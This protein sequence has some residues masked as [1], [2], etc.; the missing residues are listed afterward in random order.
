MGQSETAVADMVDI[1]VAILIAGAG[2]ELQGIKRGLIEMADLLAINKADG[3]NRPSV[4]RAVDQYRNAIRLMHPPDGPWIPRVL[5]CTPWR[6]P[7]STRSGRRCSAH[8]EAISRAG[9][10][11]E[12]RQGQMARWTRDLV[13]DHIRRFLEKDRASATSRAVWNPRSGPVGSR[14]PTQ[15]TD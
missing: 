15:P 5:S 10:F 7:A 9:L 1:F 8:R 12:R 4:A 6:T 14:P 3:D 2:D 11:E 13:N